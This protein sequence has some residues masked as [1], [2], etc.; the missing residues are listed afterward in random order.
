MFCIIDNISVS[1]VSE[2]K[3]CNETANV[4]WCYSSMYSPEFISERSSRREN[5]CENKKC[6]TLLSLNLNANLNL[7]LNNFWY[8][9]RE[10]L[11]VCI[12]WGPTVLNVSSSTWLSVSSRSLVSCK[13]LL[14]SKLLVK[15]FLL[16]PY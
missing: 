11:F 15:S 10:V 3:S 8:C 1:E 13:E 6:K 4:K 9:N 12:S 2:V 16:Y 7:S 14:P 5:D